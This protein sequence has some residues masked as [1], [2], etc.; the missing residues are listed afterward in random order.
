MKTI[1]SKNIK[2]ILWILFISF[3]TFQMFQIIQP[4]T[5]WAWDVDFLLTKQM[6]IHLDHYRLAFYTHIFTSLVVLFCGAVLFSNYILKNYAQ[7]HRAFGKAY[8]ALLL[9]F[10]APSGLIMAFYANGGWPA[11]LSFLVLVPLWWWTTYKG[12]QTARQRDFG[13]HKKWMMRSYALTL[14]AISLRIYQLIL[15]SFFYIDP[16]MQYIFVSWASWLGNLIIVEYLIYQRK[17]KM[18]KRSKSFLPVSIKV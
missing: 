17:I 16:L 8:V 3:F 12:Y 18:E 11:K 10:A 7:I 4:Y 14:S 1:P 2:S 6:I 9:L 15:G 5:T 13:E